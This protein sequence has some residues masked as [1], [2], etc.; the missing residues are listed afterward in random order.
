MRRRVRM[1][2]KKRH[3]TTTDTVPDDFKTDDVY[4]EWDIP[5]DI[6]DLNG[7]PEPPKTE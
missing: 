6:E 7:G 3:F 1:R 2:V 4:P 5:C